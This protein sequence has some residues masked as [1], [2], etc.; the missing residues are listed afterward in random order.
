MYKGDLF[1]G[2]D[3]KDEQPLYILHMVC[4][5]QIIWLW[6]L[7]ESTITIYTNQAVFHSVIAIF[8]CLKGWHTKG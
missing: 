7:L 1:E 6:S 3:P 2:G 5:W 4:T 8:M